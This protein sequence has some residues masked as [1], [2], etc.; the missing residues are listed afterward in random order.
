MTTDGFI[1]YFNL[2]TVLGTVQLFGANIENKAVFRIVQHGRV[3]III[4]FIVQQTL[5]VAV[6]KT[7]IDIVEFH[8]DLG[9][10]SIGIGKRFD[11]PGFWA[12][13]R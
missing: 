2:V 5:V 11:D 12:V 8:E 1:G 9:N 4:L 7:F 6:G 13:I 10:N 3:V